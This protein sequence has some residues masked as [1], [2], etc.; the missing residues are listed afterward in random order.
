MCDDL[1]KVGNNKKNKLY[2]IEIIYCKKCITAYQKYQVPKKKLFPPSYHYR[3]KFTKDVIS[4]LNDVVKNSKVFIGNLK[5]KIVLDVGCND[6]SLLDIFKK[7][8]SITIGIEP[9]NSA[10]EA[11]LKKLISKKTIIIVE[12]HYLGSVIEKRQFDTF[13]HEHPRTYSLKSFTKISKLLGVNL[14]SYKFPKRYGGNIRVIFSNNLTKKINFKRIMK[15]ERSYFIKI[16]KLNKDIETWKNKKLKIINALVKK[17]G[18]LPAKAFPGRAAILIKMLNLNKQQI[19]AI[20][21]R[22]KS[23]KIGNYAPGTNIPIISDKNLKKIHKNIPIINLA[24][25]ISEEIKIYLKK[26]FIKNKV[27]DILTQQDFR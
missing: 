24:W 2:K 1:I 27:I 21:E 5:G 19:S 17:F 12:N 9:T 4:G 26:N 22:D 11:N 14:I 7:E 18:P 13:Y 6:G 3:S 20:F 23:I 15:Q 25:H 16:N 10:N 8:K